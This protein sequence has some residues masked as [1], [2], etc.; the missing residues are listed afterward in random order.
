MAWFGLHDDDYFDG[1][2]MK[3][4]GIDEA[5]LR[6]WRN[7]KHIPA[8]L[9]QSHRECVQC[10]YYM[11]WKVFASDV[12]R[13][14]SN[15]KYKISSSPNDVKDNILCDIPEPM[16]EYGVYN[17]TLDDTHCTF[18]VE[19]EPVNI[20]L[21]MV[22][23]LLIYVV[24]IS[25]I[26]GIKKLI[27][28]FHRTKSTEVFPDETHPKK[29]RIKSLDTFRGISIVTMIFVNMGAGGYVILDHV[30]WNGFHLADFVFPCFLW[31]MGACI[32]ISLTSSF[33]RGVSNN[34]LIAS[35]AKRSVKL[36]CIG[37]FLGSGVY[38]DRFRVMGVLQRFGI[39][40]FVVTLI[41][42][43][44]LKRNL[45]INTENTKVRWS[46]SLE[47]TMYGWI[48]ALYAAIQH[49][50]IIFLVAD[51]GC[52]RGYFGPGGLHQH[53]KYQNCT[54]GA[55]GYLDRAILKA[56]VY[57]HPTSI[58]VY[59]SQSFDPEGFVGCLNAIFHTFIGVQ[60]GV[61]LLI[62]KDHN[63]RLAHWISWSLACFV[64]G[65]ALCGF[66]RDDGWIPI[67]KNLWS[68]SF[69]L[70][71]SHV[72]FLIL[73]VCYVLIDM[74]NYWGGQPFFYA[75]MNSILMYIG[76]QMTGNFFPFVWLTNDYDMQSRFLLL[77]QNVTAT[78]IWMYIAY[79]LYKIKYFFTV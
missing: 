9:L 38:L 63:S 12:F 28:K 70:I 10:D 37:V 42:I 22:T 21:P 6:I 16:G 7:G 45:L 65:G 34:E 53:G 27:E 11:K 67:N 66:S 57:H 72:A 78:A 58:E 48:P 41:C 71:M 60:A 43:A 8:Y 74:K 79:Y 69:V 51:E 5:Y 61:I 15:Y 75:G 19:K 3:D 77:L 14:N 13:V 59:K 76:H 36:F 68:L 18:Q 17:V 54:G 55:T 26:F 49:L 47:T 25:G 30:P 44:T 4:L 64:L 73:A 39:C 56:H 46:T 29:S 62:H 35:A 24:I 2:Y 1:L 40:Y 52:E 23:V 31:I 33:K 50:L 20:Y 32:P